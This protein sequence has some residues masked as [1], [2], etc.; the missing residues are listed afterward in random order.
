MRIFRRMASTLSIQIGTQVNGTRSQYLISEQLHQSVWRAVDQQTQ[1]N[2]VVKAAPEFFLRNERDLLKRFHHLPSLRRLVDE[3]QEPPLLVLEHLDSNLL[4]E[5]GIKKL[6]SLD[7]KRVTKA[8]LQALAALH[9]EGIV[10]TDVKPD[11]ILVNH[12]DGG[13]RFGDIKL[14]DCGDSTH[15]DSVVEEH[16]IG[17]TIFRSPEAMLNLV[18][19]TPTDI[20]SLGATAS[21]IYGEGWHI[22]TPPGID[23]TDSAHA[24]HVMRRHDQYF[25]PFPLSYKTLADDDRLETLTLIINSVEKRT[26]FSMASSQEIVREDR[27]FIRKLMQLDPRDRPSAKVLLQEPWLKE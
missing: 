3:V 1:Q 24:I 6:Q 14:A 19:G 21:L 2:V 12:G 8:V 11:N 10:H 16:I 23:P 7:V 20:W 18:W 27:E 13:S 5:S 22:F 9:E 26:P 15:I 17:A 25:G 4:I